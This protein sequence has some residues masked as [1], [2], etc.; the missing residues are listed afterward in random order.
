MDEFKKRNCEVL[1]ISVDSQF[2]HLAWKKTPIKEGGI[3]KVQY[4]MVADLDKTISRDY[5]VLL[6][7]GI[8][9]RGTFIIDKNGVIRH[10]TVN[11]LPIGRNIEEILRLIDAIQFHDSKGDVCPANWRPGEEAMKPTQEGVAE[12]LAKTFAIDN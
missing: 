1:T 3:E 7:A 6:E 11:D 5:G 4:P 10:Q 2:T 8:A 9:L 12:Y